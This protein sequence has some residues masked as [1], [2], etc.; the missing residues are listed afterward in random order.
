[1]PNENPDHDDPQATPVLNLDRL[2]ESSGHDRAVMRELAEL[3]MADCGAKLPTMVEAA[4]AIEL[5]RMHRVAHGLKGASAA[6]GCEQAAW[7]FRVV[8]EMGRAGETQGLEDAV[9]AAED[10]WRRACDSLRGLAA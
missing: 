6:M 8:E 3:Y 9:R 1:M 4:E 5:H 10:A 2:R 7:A